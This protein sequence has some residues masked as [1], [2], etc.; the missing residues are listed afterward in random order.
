[1]F[2]ILGTVEC[3]YCTMAKDFLFEKRQAYVFYKPKNKEE[4]NE[5]KQHW[6]HPTVPIILFITPHGIEYVGGFDDLSEGYERLQ[7][8]YGFSD[9]SLDVRGRDSCGDST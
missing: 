9:E 7:A 5:L 1:M 3:E 2:Y 4:L 6:S 8:T